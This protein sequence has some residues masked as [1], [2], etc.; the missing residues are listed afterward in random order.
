M[1]NKYSHNNF[2][3]FL[4][5]SVLLKQIENF[6]L[7]FLRLILINLEIENSIALSSCK[8]FQ[9]QERLDCHEETFFSTIME[10]W[11]TRL[12]HQE[13]EKVKVIRMFYK[14]DK[15]DISIFFE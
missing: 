13:V 11:R 9:K 1:T 4:P 7:I 2:I 8:C 15:R 3:Y 14:K 12:I 5:L 6:T 10:K